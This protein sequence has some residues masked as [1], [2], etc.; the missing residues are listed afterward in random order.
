MLAVIGV[1]KLSCSAKL[2]IV[3]VTFETFIRILVRPH[4]LLQVMVPGR[5]F[6]LIVIVLYASKQAILLN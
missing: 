2:V 3:C 5:L 1:I 4:T 6:L